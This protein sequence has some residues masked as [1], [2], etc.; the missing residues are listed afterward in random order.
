MITLDEEYDMRGTIMT[1]G[2][3]EVVSTTSSVAPFITVQ[4]RELLTIQTYQPRS[5]VT[6]VISKKLDYN[7]KAVPWDYQEEAKTK[8][9]NIT[10]AHGMTEIIQAL[11]VRE[12]KESDEVKISKTT[13]MVASEMLKIG[14][15]PNLGKLY[16]MQSEKKVLVQEQVPASEP[17]IMPKPGECIIEGI[18]NMFISMTEEDYG[19]NEVDL[20]MPTI[21]DAEPGEVLQH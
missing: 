5:I 17:E 2:N 18:E 7:S 4:L 13:K 1:V 21:H 20:R 15:K 3:I 16:N 14:Y 8:I 11:K 9:I 10:T 12:K 19:K 6:T